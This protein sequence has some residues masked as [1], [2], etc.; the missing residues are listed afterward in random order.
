MSD[1][2]FKPQTS[3]KKFTL[4]TL[5]QNINFRLHSQ[6]S[7]KDFKLPSQTSLLNYKVE[8]QLQRQTPITNFK[9]QSKLS[10]VDKLSLHDYWRSI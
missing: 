8:S 2:Y 7:I 4:Q 3:T 6:A 9:F 10:N 5:K 1:L